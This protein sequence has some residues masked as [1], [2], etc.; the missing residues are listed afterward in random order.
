MLAWLVYLA[1]AVSPTALPAPD[2]SVLLTGEKVVLGLMAVILFFV[3]G[4]FASYDKHLREC[5]FRE[6]EQA[7]QTQWIGDCMLM[8]G[9]RFEIALPERPEDKRRDLYDA[10]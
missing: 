3:K 9:N 1:Q 8:I 10:R 4:K 2:Y 7:R 5:H 6:V